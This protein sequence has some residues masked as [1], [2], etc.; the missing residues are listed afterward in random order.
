MTADNVAFSSDER[1]LPKNGTPQLLSTSAGPAGVG[2][3]GWD[4]RD[5]LYWTQWKK[6]TFLLLIGPISFLADFGSSTA[7]VTFLSQSARWKVPLPTINHALVGGQFMIGACSL[8][9][10]T[11]SAYFGRL[12]VLSYFLTMSLAIAAYYRAATNFDSLMTARILNAFFFSSPD[13]A[14]GLMWIK[15]TY[16]PHEHARKINMWSS[17]IAIAPFAGPL[18]SAF[19]VSRTTWRLIF[20]LLTMLTAISW[21]SCLLF[22]D[23]T[24]VNRR[25]VGDLFAG[26]KSRLLRLLAIELR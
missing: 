3:S 8:L 22:L 21:A 2:Q 11:L 16:F 26:Q 10:V 13:P 15:D 25:A 23:E 4:P 9:V 24:F 6:D 7:S 17:F 1:L 5:P 12:L 14:G 18:V 19:V 20:W